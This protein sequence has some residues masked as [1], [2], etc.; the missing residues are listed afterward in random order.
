[1]PAHA[2]L[3]PEELKNTALSE[4]EPPYRAFRNQDYNRLKPGAPPRPEELFD[5]PEGGMTVDSVAECAMECTKTPKCNAASWYGASSS[6]VDVRN[7]WLKTLEPACQLPADAERHSDNRAFLIA[8]PR[9]C[10]HFSCTIGSCKSQCLP[11]WVAS[12]CLHLQISCH[13]WAR[14]ERFPN[15][16]HR[17]LQSML[18]CSVRKIEFHQSV[19]MFAHTS[20]EQRGAGCLPQ[21]SCSMYTNWCA[22]CLQGG[23][24]PH[25]PCTCE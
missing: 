25:G 20:L 7:C 5:I 18:R 6:W 4:L 17:S 16:N 13:L 8:R 9:E 24:V 15:S 23:S 2:V 12:G 11:A 3:T 21:T 14:A 1:M 19:C 10:E 22:C